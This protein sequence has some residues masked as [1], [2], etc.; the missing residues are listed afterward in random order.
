MSGIREI[1]IVTLCYNT[2][3][4]VLDTLESIK[5]QTFKN[6]ELVIVDDNSTDDSK[7]LL[8][9]WVKENDA[10]FPISFVKNE[11][12]LGICRSLNKG[13][14]KATGKYFA[15]IGDDVWHNS[16]LETLH[17]VLS[18]AP[19]TI[20]MAYAKADVMD[21]ETKEKAYYLDPMEYIKDSAY[22]EK[23]T[24]FRAEGNDIYFLAGSLVQ[25]CLFY[26]NVFTSFTGLI[27][28][29]SLKSVGYYKES[30]S[31]EDLPTWFS[32][33]K[34]YDFLFVD[35]YLATYVRHDDSFTIKNKSKL[36][37]GCIDIYRFNRDLAK[38]KKLKADLNGILFEFWYDLYI[39]KNLPRKDLLVYTFKVMF[40]SRLLFR[41]FLSYFL[42]KIIRDSG[43]KLKLLTVRSGQAAG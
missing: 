3:R 36:Y 1:T 22:P 30:F 7:K 24:L 13:L 28:L 21:Y 38:S 6:F 19:P 15:L 17:T 40:F 33:S 11:E 4:Y 43:K 9:E 32:L 26:C 12:N 27:K 23:D 5:A 41:K 2:G 18:S 10:L 42:H 20:C 14:E 34:K 29:E 16:L 37:K 39:D 25:K 31:F 8:D 35:R